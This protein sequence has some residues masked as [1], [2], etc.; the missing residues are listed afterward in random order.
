MRW[1]NVVDCVLILAVPLTI[2]VANRLGWPQRATK[3]MWA[4]LAA[5]VIWHSTMGTANYH[6]YYDCDQAPTHHHC[7]QPFCNDSDD[8]PACEA[9]FDPDFPPPSP[10]WI[11]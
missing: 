11:P 5:A 8:I 6:L 9:M 10:R 7:W 4:T 1:W 2:Y 3:A